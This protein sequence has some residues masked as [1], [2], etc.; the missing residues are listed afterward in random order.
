[1]SNG[2]SSRLLFPAIPTLTKRRST[3]LQSSISVPSP[4]VVRRS[5]SIKSPPSSAV[6]NVTERLQCISVRDVLKPVI[7]GSSRSLLPSLPSRKMSSQQHDSI[8]TS[9]ESNIPASATVGVSQTANVPV[10]RHVGFANG[11][12]TRLAFLRCLSRFDIDVS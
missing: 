9:R 7:T 4:A 1:M 8:G 12:L 6:D 10:Y 2:H 5:S 3:P 11:I